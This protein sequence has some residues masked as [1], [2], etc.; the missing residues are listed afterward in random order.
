MAEQDLL[1]SVT[2]NIPLISG[3]VDWSFILYIMGAAIVGMVAFIFLRKHFYPY[4]LI[5]T[6]KV[7]SGE[8]V[9]T[10]HGKIMSRDGTKQLHVYSLNKYIPI[11]QNRNLLPYRGLFKKAAIQYYMDSDG[12]LVENLLEPIPISDERHQK[13]FVPKDQTKSYWAQLQRV[14]VQQNYGEFWNKYGQ[15][16]AQGAISLVLIVVALIIMNKFVEATG[17]LSSALREAATIAQTLR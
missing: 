7:G 16:V 5:I 1:G 3:G 17:T 8:S 12:E 11:P 9:I 4:L 2:Q 13:T 14:R 15:L 10:D 6:R